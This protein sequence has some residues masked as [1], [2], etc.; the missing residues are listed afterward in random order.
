MDGSDDH[1]SYGSALCCP[2]AIAFSYY[3]W[4][5]NPGQSTNPGSDI[6]AA[7]TPHACGDTELQIAIAR[8][9][10]PSPFLPQGRTCDGFGLPEGYDMNFPLCYDP[11]S[12]YS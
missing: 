5:N 8:K 6:I 11:S 9:V 1:N 7:C 12:R 10:S 2:Q 4:S 3:H